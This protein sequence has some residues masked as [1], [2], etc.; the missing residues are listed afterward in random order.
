ME[1]VAPVVL[2]AQQEMSEPDQVL[3][4]AAVGALLAVNLGEQVVMDTYSLLT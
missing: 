1:T 4:V 3:A 2:V